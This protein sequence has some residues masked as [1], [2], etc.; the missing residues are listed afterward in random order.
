[1]IR[2]MDAARTTRLTGF[3]E[4]IASIRGSRLSRRLLMYIVLCSSFFT[5]LATSFQLYMDYKRDV[6]AIHGSI[7]F[8]KAGYRDPLAVSAYNMDYNGL[9]LLLKG[10]LKFRDIEYL[11]ISEP[12]PEGRKILARE[13][14]PNAQRDI[15]DEVILRYPA[16][17]E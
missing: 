4:H 17:P 9:K 11:E 8:I 12:F 3:P 16:A 15:V 1:M 13:G 7:Q 5:L 2:N 10:V 6:W 14:N